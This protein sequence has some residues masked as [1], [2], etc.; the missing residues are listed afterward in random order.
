MKVIGM[1]FKAEKKQLKFMAPDM[2]IHVDFR[3]ELTVK[4]PDVF[5]A[6]INGF[7]A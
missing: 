6:Q 2:E 1:K 3:N 5:P 4:T 7:P